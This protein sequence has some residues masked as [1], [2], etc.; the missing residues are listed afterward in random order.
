MG[1]FLGM[2]T[3]Q[4]RGAAHALD[5]LAGRL[6]TEAGHVKAE[7][8][9][10][11][12]EG[13]DAEAFRARMA[14]VFAPQVHAVISQLFALAHALESNA[15]EQDLASSQGGAQVS[16]AGPSPLALAGAAQ[17]NLLGLGILA[18]QGARARDL[19]GLTSRRVRGIGTENTHTFNPTVGLTALA[20]MKYLSSTGKTWFLNPHFE[21]TP[22]TRPSTLVGISAY[23]DSHPPR[24]LADLL[25]FTEEARHARGAGE[26]R[27]NYRVQ[28]FRTAAGEETYVMYM[29]PTQIDMKKEKAWDGT[30]GNS[31]DWA[32]NL[33]IMAGMDV[34]TMKNARAA[35]E[36]AGVPKGANLMLVGHSQGGLAAASLASRSDFNGQD[37]YNVTNVITYGSPVDAFTPAQSN[38]KVFAIAHKQ[39]LR[40]YAESILGGPSRS[41]ISFTVD[42]V[43][44]LDLG[45]LGRPHSPQVTNIDLTPATDHDAGLNTGVSF[46]QPGQAPVDVKFPG[47]DLGAAHDS[48]ERLPDGSINPHY[49]YYPTVL[50][51]QGLN[52]ELLEVKGDIDGLYMGEGLTLIDDTNVQFVRTPE[53]ASGGGATHGDGGTDRSMPPSP[54]EFLDRWR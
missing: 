18:A 16:G 47:Y 15:L 31:R 43:P 46:F 12:W 28:H 51:Q 41:G 25:E 14:G 13:A 40:T 34:T 38:T 50:A 17:A 23:R 11:P 54:E 4:V 19:L 35:L 7:A 49:G 29:P 44:L 10:A 21:V 30:A 48:M 52:P 39:G 3:A 42:P 53:N 45:G 8:G 33:G 5:E 36:A 37:G 26:N 22:T 27:E 32:S 20:A 9:A 24:E 1:N 2:D 6:N